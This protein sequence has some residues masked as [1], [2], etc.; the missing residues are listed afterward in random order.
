M[1]GDGGKHN[2]THD[3]AQPLTTGPLTP[4]HSLTHLAP[5]NSAAVDSCAQPLPG[6]INHSPNCPPLL[7]PSRESPQEA[8]KF[9]C[10]SASSHLCLLARG[11]STVSSCPKTIQALHVQDP[12]LRAHHPRL[13]SHTHI[14]QSLSLTGGE[15]FLFVAKTIQTFLN[16]L[17]LVDPCL[18]GQ[19]P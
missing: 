12:P 4:S 3:H 5:W 1:E 7:A 13:T 15:P 14:S 10:S 17:V 2:P 11:T 6:T 18:V 16:H 8:L 9:T 19:G